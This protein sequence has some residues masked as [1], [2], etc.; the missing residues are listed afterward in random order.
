MPG[1]R[2][3]RETGAHTKVSIKDYEFEVQEEPKDF[4]GWVK[5]GRYDKEWRVMDEHLTSE[6]TFLDLGA[7]IGSHSLYASRVAKRVVAVEPDPIACSIL[8]KNVD[9]APSPIDVLDCAIIGNPGSVTLGS[10][11]LGASTT[12]IN[13]EAGG[14]IGP[15]EEGQSFTTW[16]TTIRRLVDKLGLTDPLFIKMDVEG[17]EED[18]LEDIDFFAKHNP[19]LYLEQHPWWWKDVSTTQKRIEEVSK[20]CR[21]VW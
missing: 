21:V 4:W 5:E 8:K 13:P 2:A 6:H 10:G 11:L 19:V 12:R 14:G 3:V 17:S 7:W 9:F 1:K 15:W 16:G 18:I 20:V